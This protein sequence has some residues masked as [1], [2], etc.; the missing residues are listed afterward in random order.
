M[1]IYFNIMVKI[2]KVEEKLRQLVELALDVIPSVKEIRVFG[3][4]NSRDWDPEKSDIDVS[5]ETNDE[6]YSSFWPQ[7][8][9]NNQRDDIK[10][11]FIRRMNQA[12]LSYRF[13]VHWFTSGDIKRLSMRNQG[14]GSL[15]LNIKSGRLIYPHNQLIPKGYFIEKGL[16][17][18]LILH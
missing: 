16:I 5:V 17:K 14:R 2:G 12:D 9:D 1:K 6:F 8:Y 4:Y 13:E 7:F 18:N 11:E 15:G 3:S 10:R